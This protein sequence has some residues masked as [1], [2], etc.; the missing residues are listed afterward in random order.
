MSEGQDPNRSEVFEL[1]KLGASLVLGGRGD[2]LAE[3]LDD[4]RTCRH[5]D[6]LAKMSAALEEAGVSGER[7]E[8]EVRAKDE[9]QELFESVV[10]AA[11]R[12]RYDEKIAYLGRVMASAIDGTGGAILDGQWLRV[13]AVEHLEPIHVQ[14]LSVLRTDRGACELFEIRGIAED[15]SIDISDFEACMGLLVRHGLVAERVQL[16]LDIDVDI[17]EPGE[18]GVMPDETTTN[19]WRSEAVPTWRLTELGVEIVSALRESS[20]EPAPD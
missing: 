4:R 3:Y 19:I 16:E 18:P 7:L 20:G 15:R 5:R 8:E 2:A 17:D 13:R 10:S 9:T 6:R 14:L 1:A 12:S 11:A